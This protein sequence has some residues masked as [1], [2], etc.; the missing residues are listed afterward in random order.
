[1]Y[2]TDMIFIRLFHSVLGLNELPVWAD[3][4]IAL[5]LGMI[6]YTIVRL[7]VVA[8]MQASIDSMSSLLNC[9]DVVS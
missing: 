9:L 3:V 5:L 4:V 8:K 7:V 6:S 2:M 1:M